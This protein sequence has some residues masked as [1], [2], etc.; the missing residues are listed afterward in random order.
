MLGRFRAL[1]NDVK[2]GVFLFAVLFGALHLFGIALLVLT[3]YPDA[4]I[5]FLGADGVMALIFGLFRL[6]QRLFPTPEDS[7]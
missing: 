2:Q 6:G 3:G 5:G 7:P 4:L 1:S